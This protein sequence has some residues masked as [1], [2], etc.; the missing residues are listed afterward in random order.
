MLVREPDIVK[1]VSKTYLEIN[2]AAKKPIPLLHTVRC[3]HEYTKAIRALQ[4]L[5]VV[6]ASRYKSRRLDVSR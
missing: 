5:G 6:A 2:F 3:R 1:V 4:L